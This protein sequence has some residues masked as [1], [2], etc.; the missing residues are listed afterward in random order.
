MA[1][2]R[3][4]TYVELAH[5]GY[6][7]ETFGQQQS[8]ATRVYLVPWE[9]RQ[10]AALDFL[11]YVEAD[12]LGDPPIPSR[13][14]PDYHPGYLRPD[15]TPFLWA[16][17]VTFEP[18][19]QPMEDG[20]PIYENGAMMDEEGEPVYNQAK[21][22]VHYSTRLYR[23]MD[24]GELQNGANNL[25]EA[26]LLRYVEMPVSVAAQYLTLPDGT[27]V[28]STDPDGFNYDI[29][30]NKTGLSGSVLGAP[31]KIESTWDVT[32]I[33]RQVPRSMVAAAA[34]NAPTDGTETQLSAI[35]YAIGRVNNVTFAGYPPGTLLCETP[36][37]QQWVQCDGEIVFDVTFHFK[38]FR[39]GWNYLL[40][41]SVPTDPNSP[42]SFAYGQVAAGKDG[43]ATYAPPNSSPLSAIWMY[44]PY[45]FHNLF[46]GYEY[47]AGKPPTP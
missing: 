4:T 36:E 44:L 8:E 45:D 38:Y 28:F 17:S 30:G 24:D 23:I 3:D 16:D 10:Q 43:T 13:I 46:Y 33:W 29:N 39:W 9:E 27:F 19:G 5:Q 18:F 25:G 31:G 35:D 2:F 37:F 47:S 1:T 40:Q 22:T 26:S 21:M 34:V 12:P 32:I 7:Q 6:P 42:A 20:Q 15:A 14:I 41:K 11:G